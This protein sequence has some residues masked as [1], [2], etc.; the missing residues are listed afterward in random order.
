M[1]MKK[2]A[3]IPNP[4]HTEASVQ[5]PHHSIALHRALILSAKH[6]TLLKHIQWDF[7]ARVAHI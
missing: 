6:H 5:L 2:A 4:R 3:T 1:E 7:S